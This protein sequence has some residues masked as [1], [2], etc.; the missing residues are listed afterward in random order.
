M[1]GEF[2]AQYYL[3]DMYRRGH[4]VTQDYTLAVWWYSAAAD[5]DYAAAQY[6]LGLMYRRGLGL[7]RD[8]AEAVRWF[9][10]AANQEHVRAKAFLAHMFYI[11]H[12]VQQDFAEAA[13]WYRAAAEQGD[14]KSQARFAKM[15]Y[16]GDGVKR[17]YLEAAKWYRRLAGQGDSEAPFRL[18][19]MYYNGE[20][21]KRDYIRSHKWFDVAASRVK[22]GKARSEPAK[23]RDIVAR[24]MTAIQIEEAQRLSREWQDKQHVAAAPPLPPTRQR[25]SRIQQGLASIGYSHGRAD[26][27]FGP[28]TRA[29][30]RA[31]QAAEG[32]PTTGKVSTHLETALQSATPPS[33]AGH[34]RRSLTQ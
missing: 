8:D 19:V 2:R 15:L 30:I 12:G 33:R 18:G 3:G 25:V 34:R 16:Y 31:F 14:T 7:V 26:G 5:Q 17:N 21:V 9:C 27:I 22:S 6:A 23:N 28:R 1:Q 10:A 13:R 4:G 11:G 20:G 29:A 24:R 32:L